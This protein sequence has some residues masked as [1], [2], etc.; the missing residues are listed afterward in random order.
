MLAIG[1][2]KPTK[3]DWS[4][5]S[6]AKISLDPWRYAQPVSATM[7]AGIIL[8]YLLFSPIGLV[9]GLSVYFWWLVLLVIGMNAV[10]CKYL[11]HRFDRKYNNSD[12]L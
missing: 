3:E 7:L 10:V 2:W 6:V 4:Y 8:L 12:V 5:N 11:L 9:G 1:K